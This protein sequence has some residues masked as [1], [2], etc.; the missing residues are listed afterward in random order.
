[1][2]INVLD[3]LV[4]V[5]VFV[6]LP[7]LFGYSYM[8]CWQLKH[9]E[10]MNIKLLFKSC[11]SQIELQFQSDRKVV[12]ARRRR[13]QIIAF[14]FAFVLVLLKPSW[15]VSQFHSNQFVRCVCTFIFLSFTPPPPPSLSLCISSSIVRSLTCCIHIGN[16]K[17]LGTNHE[18]LIRILSSNR[19]WR[20]GTFVHI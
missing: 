13:W 6:F 2:S 5:S 18:T 7:L 8:L 20:N 9:D 19:K 14:A 12:C 3:H 1:M 4:C 16:T 11:Y 17:W 15:Y 10:I